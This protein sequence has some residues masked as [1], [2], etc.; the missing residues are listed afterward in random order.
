MY[1]DHLQSI[2]KHKTLRK[3]G[4]NQHFCHLWCIIFERILQNDFIFCCCA[5]LFDVNNCL[6]RYF[7]SF[8]SKIKNIALKSVLYIIGFTVVL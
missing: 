5:V 6:L 4:G 2:Y 1:I 8:D 7:Q 3:R